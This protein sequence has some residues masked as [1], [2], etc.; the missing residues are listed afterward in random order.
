MIY[1][2]VSGNDGSISIS[3]LRSCSALS[4]GAKS[5]PGTVVTLALAFTRKSRVNVVRVMSRRPGRSNDASL[6]KPAIAIASPS[7]HGLALVGERPLLLYDT[8]CAQHHPFL[9]P[10]QFL[11]YI[12]WFRL[13]GSVVK[14]RGFKLPVA[15]GI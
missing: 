15:V 12:L 3:R 1:A 5:S 10:E 13:G 8:S 2:Y 6:L 11:H 7:L 9:V 14:H 4:K